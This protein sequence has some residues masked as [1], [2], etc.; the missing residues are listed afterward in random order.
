M[1]TRSIATGIP[2]YETQHLPFPAN[3]EVLTIAGHDVF[4]YISPQKIDQIVTRL[5]EQIEFE[6]FDAVVV[7]MRGGQFLYEKLKKEKGYEGGFVPVEYHRPKNGVG[8]EITI[9]IPDELNGK[10]CLLIDDISD[11]GDT[12]MAMLENLAPDS[13]SVA[14][15]SKRDIPDKKDVPNL[16]IG[17]TIDGFVWIAGCGMD[18]SYENEADEFRNYPGIVVKIPQTVMPDGTWIYK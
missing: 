10:K 16:H 14:L 4:D 8:T 5:G 17:V 12:F 13:V 11:R 9:P 2:D 1:T 18:I 7:N 15:I 6:R 3:P